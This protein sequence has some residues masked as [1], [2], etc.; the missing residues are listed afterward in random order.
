M[1]KIQATQLHER[2]GTTNHQ[3]G[4]GGLTLKGQEIDI[5]ESDDDNDIPGPG[6]YFDD[7]NA[8]T[9]FKTGKKPERL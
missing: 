1:S 7:P 9:S 4:M 8:L 5:F 3:S 6:A 2:P